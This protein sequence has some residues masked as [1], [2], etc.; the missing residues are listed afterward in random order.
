MAD[1]FDRIL[2]NFEPLIMRLLKK[3]KGWDD[4]ECTHIDCE[5][6]RSDFYGIYL[7]YYYLDGQNMPA[8]LEIAITF[9]RDLITH[10]SW[11]DKAA[12]IPSSISLEDKLLLKLAYL[13]W[14]AKNAIDDSFIADD[15]VANDIYNARDPLVEV[16]VVPSGGYTF[17]VSSR[18]I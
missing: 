16:K 18:T 11:L 4:N 6:Y 15:K 7:E 10:R 3:N 1:Y 14:H 13:V 9:N 17:E 12:D 5:K 2:F 8:T